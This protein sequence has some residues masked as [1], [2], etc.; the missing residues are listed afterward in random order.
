[1]QYF[2]YFGLDLQVKTKVLNLIQYP[3]GSQS[4]E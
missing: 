1:M 4:K 2:V 3:M